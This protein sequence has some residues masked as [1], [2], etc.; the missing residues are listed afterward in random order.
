MSLNTRLFL[1]VISL[2]T[3]FQVEL[4]GERVG[5]VLW[6]LSHIVGLLSGK[7]EVIYSAPRNTSA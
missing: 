4:L 6:C 7:S 3:Y 2:E 5:T 1:L